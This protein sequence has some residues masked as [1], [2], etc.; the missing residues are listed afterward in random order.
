MY[1]AYK[2]NKQGDDI[3]LCHTAFPVLNQSVILCPVLIVA[4][5]PAYRLLRRQARWSGSPISLRIFH[6]L[7]WTTQS[8][9]SIVNEANVFLEFPCFLYDTTN[10][11]NLIAG[12]SAFTIPGLYIWRCYFFT[13]LWKQHPV[14]DVTGD[15][16]KVWC[17]KEQYCIRTWNVRSMGQTG[18][19]KSEYQHFRKQWTKMD[20]NGR[21]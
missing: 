10:V 6:S 20:W 15:G 13:L 1:S 2:L 18:D 3:Q 9:F 5:C 11:G 4:S 12:S 8:D 14:V 16:S 7:L 17:C 19:G 21:I